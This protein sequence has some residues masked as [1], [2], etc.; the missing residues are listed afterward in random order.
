MREILYRRKYHLLKNDYNKK[1]I[2]SCEI[3]FCACIDFN[4]NGCF[5]L[6]QVALFENTQM[7]MTFFL[8]IQNISMFLNIFEL[9][10]VH[11]LKTK[12]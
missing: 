11:H 1:Q 4:C 6:L 12:S 2:N 3:T 10:N 5:M 8:K 9:I 7:Q